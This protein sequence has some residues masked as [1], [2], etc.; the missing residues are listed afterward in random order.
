MSI[1]YD[2]TDEF[3]KYVVEHVRDRMVKEIADSL[4]GK[5][6][7]YVS[8]PPFDNEA[9]REYAYRLAVWAVASTLG[10]F[11]FMLDDY[12]DK[13]QLLM[14][15]NGEKINKYPTIP[16]AMPLQ[17]Q[18]RIQW[19]CHWWPPILPASAPDF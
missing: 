6:M 7:H 15:Y 16:H 9:Q 18:R 4:D 13:F 2:A 17:N 11:F 14:D 10:E 12:S 19:L 5:G 3:G 8:P 1:N